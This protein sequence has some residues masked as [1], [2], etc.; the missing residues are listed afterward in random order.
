MY[1]ISYSEGHDTWFYVSPRAQFEEIL[2]HV[3]AA[4]CIQL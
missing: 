3:A 4:L 1:R 2:L